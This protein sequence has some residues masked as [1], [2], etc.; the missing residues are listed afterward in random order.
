M[1]STPSFWAS[2]ALR[3]VPISSPLIR[4]PLPKSIVPDASIPSS[5]LGLAKLIDAIGNHH[6]R[7]GLSFAGTRSQ[8]P[9]GGEQS[10]GGACTGAAKQPSPDRLD[11]H[12]IEHQPLLVN[13]PPQA[14][15]LLRRQ[16]SAGSLAHQSV[17][18]QTPIACKL[19]VD[20]RI[21]WV[22]RLLDVVLF[23]QF[24]LVIELDDCSRRLALCVD[25][26]LLR[27]QTRL[28][29]DGCG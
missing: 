10:C 18:F 15:D 21:P 17:A 14:I 26:F 12:A 29:C 8:T 3:G 2:A 27:F 19:A 1:Q 23:T 11:Q 5:G 7:F 22:S 20:A 4:R 16:V 28:V 6:S 24:C 13:V 9:K 25:L